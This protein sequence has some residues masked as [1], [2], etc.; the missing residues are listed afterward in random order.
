MGARL[1][2]D[3]AW[4]AFDVVPLRSVSICDAIDFDE[5]DFIAVLGLELVNYFIPCGHE[6]HA[7]VT[8]WHEKVNYD[9]LII[10]SCVNLLLKLLGRVGHGAFGLFPPVAHFVGFECACVCVC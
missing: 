9:N 1:Q 8:S 4:E 2:K 7:V 3:E 10:A 5:L 6:L